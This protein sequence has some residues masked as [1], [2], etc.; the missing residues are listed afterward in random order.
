MEMR[1]TNVCTARAG[2]TFYD[3][4][5][6]LNFVATDMIKERNEKMYSECDV[7]NRCIRSLLC[8]TGKM[9]SD[10][11]SREFLDGIMTWRSDG[12]Q[13]ESSG[14]W[15]PDAELNFGAN[16]GK[17]LKRK[18]GIKK[19]WADGQE[20]RE[21]KENE[22]VSKRRAAALRRKNAGQLTGQHQVRCT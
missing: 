8:S 4:I 10:R 11:E 12:G 15:F 13:K 17:L 20:H 14:S 19:R 3:P 1:L 7:G 16:V 9:R 5:Y 2:I 22:D 6:A 18:S 21:I